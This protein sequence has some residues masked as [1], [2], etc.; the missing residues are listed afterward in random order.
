MH[1]A[2]CSRDLRLGPTALFTFI[3]HKPARP[4]KT[5]NLNQRLENTPPELQNQV[6]RIRADSSTCHCCQRSHRL[7]TVQSPCWSEHFDHGGYAVSV[8]AVRCS[9]T[10]TIRSWNTYRHKPTFD[11]V[12][13]CC[14]PGLGLLVFV[15]FRKQRSQASMT[16]P[17]RTKPAKPENSLNCM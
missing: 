17:R 9:D 5:S 2:S 10:S 7:Y 4:A 14:R 3:H 1:Y 11:L 8:A 13:R 12:F 6:G 16:L 15:G